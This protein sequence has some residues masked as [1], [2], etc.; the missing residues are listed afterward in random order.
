[1]FKRIKIFSKNKKLILF[2]FLQF[3][4]SFKL[5]KDL[6]Q[7]FDINYKI[8]YLGDQGRTYNTTVIFTLFHFEKSKHPFT[9]YDRWSNRFIK[10][11]GAPIVA[12][13]DYYWEKKI[14][15]RCQKYNITGF[16]FLLINNFSRFFKFLYF[17][18]K[19][20]K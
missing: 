18:F 7:N 20:K 6:N 1:M 10:S 9:H 8:V 3:I 5:I 16:S 11:I 2:I 4:I 15:K 19:R 12:F 14:I 13:I 17:K